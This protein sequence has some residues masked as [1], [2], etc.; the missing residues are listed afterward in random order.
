MA[1]GKRVAVLAQNLLQQEAQVGVRNLSKGL[2]DDDAL[3]FRVALT[4][5]SKETGEGFF[6]P[7]PK[8]SALN[9]SICLI[10]STSARS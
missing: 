9:R 7:S 8:Y 2:V 1:T 3:L 4:Y 6:L 10:L 5:G